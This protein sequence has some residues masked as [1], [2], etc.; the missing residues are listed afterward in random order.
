[1]KSI[2]FG[3]QHHERLERAVK[4]YERGPTG[5]YH[6]DNWLP[7]TV[8]LAVGAFQGSFEASFQ[9][10]EL[11]ELH[12]SLS[13]LYEALSGKVEFRT[14]EEQLRLEFVGNGRGSIEVRGEALDQPGIGNR[15]SFT[16]QL[17]QSQLG[18]SVQ[19]L[20]VAVAAFPVRT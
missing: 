16:L 12:E 14:L 19:A 11:L 9:A 15:L 3:G 7:V 13:E 17:D 18:Q 5:D 4:G 20:K 8:S 10:V 2:V 6:D 1:M